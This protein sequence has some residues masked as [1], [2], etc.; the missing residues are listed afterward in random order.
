MKSQTFTTFAL[1]STLALSVAAQNVQSKP[2]RLILVTDDKKLDGTALGSCH[3]G[4]G[5]EGLCTGIPASSTAEYSTF[6]FNTSVGETAANKTA[7]KTGVL[8]YE[9]EGGNFNREQAGRIRFR[10]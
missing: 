1:L 8:T 9:L 5:F 6:R 7:G 10:L 4:A 2:F 3:E